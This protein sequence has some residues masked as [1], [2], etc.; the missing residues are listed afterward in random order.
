MNKK[1]KNERIGL[2]ASLCISQIARGE[3]SI[4]SVDKIISSTCHETREGWK[5][6]M[7]GYWHEKEFEACYSILCQ[8]LDSGKI[9]Q[10]RR[11]ISKCPHIGETGSL[12][13]SSERQIK[14]MNC[15]CPGC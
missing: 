14:W 8:L 11:T 5:E 4:D 7:N 12:W 1:A 15:S 13:V 10:P 6:G 3:V 2:S 9:E